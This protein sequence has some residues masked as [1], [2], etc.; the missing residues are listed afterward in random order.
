MI[1]IVG[2]VDALSTDARDGW[3]SAAQLRDRL[4]NGRK[5]AIQILE[6]FDRQGLTIRRGDLRRINPQKL[7]L[8]GPRTEKSVRA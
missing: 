3:F 1:E 8:F 6:N 4:D 7:D 2:I 5:I